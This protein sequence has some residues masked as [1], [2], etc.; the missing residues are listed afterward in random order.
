MNIPE[1]KGDW[2]DQKGKLKKKFVWL[3]D[4]D[5]VYEEG[6]KEAMLRKLQIILGKTQP[7]LYRIIEEL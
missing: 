1:L 2:S 3:T 6:K 7:E 4:S 5:L